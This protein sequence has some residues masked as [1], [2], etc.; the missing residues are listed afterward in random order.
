MV[1]M[2]VE[3][4]GYCPDLDVQGTGMVVVLASEV[5]PHRR[6]SLWWD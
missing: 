4:L 1:Q 5:V 3:L 6:W 2:A